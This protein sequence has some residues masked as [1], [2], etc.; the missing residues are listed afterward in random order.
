MLDFM[1]Q[2]LKVLELM[3]LIILLIWNV[4]ENALPGATCTGQTYI[5]LFN[6]YGSIVA[7]DVYLNV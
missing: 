2:L 4:G 5:R 1:F 3:I 6:Q 7:S